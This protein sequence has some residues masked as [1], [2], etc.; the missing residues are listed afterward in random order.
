[1]AK[2][3]LSR[4]LWKLRI[5]GFLT[6][7]LMA[8]LFSICTTDFLSSFHRFVTNPKRDNKKINNSSFDAEPGLGES[9]FF[10]STLMATFYG[11]AAFAA[12]LSGVLV[13]CVPFWYQYLAYTTALIAGSVLYG[14]SNQSWVLVLSLIT[15]GLY[16]GAEGS[17][18]NNY[19][20]KLSNQYV[21][22]LE[23]KGDTI[24]NEQEKV[25]IR[26]YLYTAHIFGQGIGFIIGTAIGVLFAQL[27]IEQYRS[28]AWFNVAC[29]LVILAVFAFFFRGESEWKS[30]KISSCGSFC[31][32]N[33]MCTQNTPGP[34]QVFIII[35]FLLLN[36]V[37]TFKWSYFEV[38]LN[39]V[40]SDSFGLSLEV[41]SYFYLGLAIP[42]ILGPI[43]VAVLQ[44]VNISSQTIRII[45]FLLSIT[46]YALL[47]DWQ[48]ISYDPCTEY[49][50]FHHPKLFQTQGILSN[51]S[52]DSNS[53]TKLN[54]TS[55]KFVLNIFSNVDLEFSD[56]I[57][58][59]FI[60]PLGVHYICKE[61]TF[62]SENNNDRP[63]FSFQ[64]NHFGHSSISKLD[65]ENE[66]FYQSFS[67]FQ[68]NDTGSKQVFC[69]NL[70]QDKMTSAVS[71]ASADIQSLLVLPDDIY[72]KET[73]L[74]ALNAV[75]FISLSIG[76]VIADAL[77]EATQKRI[78]LLSI[79]LGSLNIPFLIGVIVLYR[80]LGPHLKYT[81]QYYKEQQD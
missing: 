78:F 48:A 55:S 9:E 33:E 42:R 29:G 72:A 31:E 19:A 13:R 16:V 12:L 15:I 67:C 59:E 20:N 18:A 71:L 4:E 27:H 7:I 62:C 64:Y 46:G 6:Q 60:I 11:I 30:T 25:K 58:L 5:N 69:V 2:D 36:F 14:I 23:K 53:S 56:G 34:L 3:K 63:T 80:Q 28:M 66:I 65:T 79:L 61:D 37:E 22:A 41:S 74:G 24:G 54:I 77:Y 17:L 68:A 32:S 1:M 73:V 44:K 10:Y 40:L 50:P 26:N 51:K 43:L 8:L 38:L 70:L 57:K 81:T 39:P 49:S 45:G 47:T 52:N 35:S 75:S 21:G 76:P